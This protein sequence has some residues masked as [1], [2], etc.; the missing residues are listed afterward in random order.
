MASGS[1]SPTPDTDAAGAADS[2]AAGAADSTA[3][4]AGG[5]GSTGTPDQPEPTDELVVTHHRLPTPDG[6]LGY[7]VTT[8]RIVLRE[9]VLTD[10]AF[11]GHK[12]VVEMFVVAYTLDDADPLARPVTFA[13][14]G[15]P[16]SSSVWLH[17]GLLGPRRVVSGDVDSPAPPPYGLADNDETLFMHSDL[18]FIDPVS[19]GFTRT[20]KGGKPA[21]YHGFKADRDAVAELIRL[22][23]TRNNRWLSP[24]FLAGESYGTLRAAAL[25]G[26]LAERHGMALNGIML[27]SAV[28]DMG[29][30]FFTPGNDDPYALFLPTYAALAHYHGKHPN[31]TLAEVVE[32]ARELAERDYLWALARGAR[33][34]A[35]RRRNIAERIASVIGLPVDY[36]LRADLR[37]EHQHFF[38]ELRRSENL[39]IGRLDGRFVGTPA[40][41][42]AA[43]LTADPSYLAIQA[44]Y[45]AAINHYLRAELGYSSDL[46]YE[47]LTANVWPWSYADFE[48]R[49]VSVVDDLSA[50]MRGNPFLKVHVAFGYYDGATPFA[51]A[52]QTIA[53][54]RIPSAL[55]DNI[56]G[57]YYEAGHM[58]YVHEPSR[59]TQS[60]DLA[61]FVRWATGGP[62]PAS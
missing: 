53:H 7:T 1:A 16:G 52:E 4:G 60:A 8:G 15:G 61:E 59:L 46:P 3:A 34:S 21:T 48:N 51:A 58:M 50:A 28:I 54:L 11:D 38:A 31:R 39:A 23:T 33:L 42:N 17:L 45:T 27:I 20:V 2:D 25:A 19:T 30:V 56:S 40:D 43:T 41:G 47:V 62:A 10:G 35:R 9:E 6:E 26:R 5:K 24:K 36:V 14:N 55:H 29:T 49:S 12:A 32:E 13:F 37:I 44:P 22:W 18:V 57:R